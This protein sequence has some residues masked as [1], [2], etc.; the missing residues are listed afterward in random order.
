MLGALQDS[1]LARMGF[2]ISVLVATLLVTE[3]THIL[4]MLGDFAR[5]F[6]PG[7]FCL[8][9]TDHFSPGQAAIVSCTILYVR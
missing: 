1:F 3:T 2:R 8:I 4:V 6:S 5:L 7:S 9:I